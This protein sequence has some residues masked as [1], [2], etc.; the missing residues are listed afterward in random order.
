MSSVRTLSPPA[1]RLASLLPAMLLADDVEHPDGPLGL[2]LEVLAG[3]LTDLEDAVDRLARDPFVARASAEALPLIAALV[4]ARL[5]GDDTA[6]NRM[7]VA[8]T[9]GWRRRKGTLRTL[10][11]VLTRTSGWP[12]EVDEGFRSLLVTQDVTEPLPSRGWTALLWDPVGLADPLTRRAQH[13]DRHPRAAL[14]SPAAGD[15]LTEAL[16]RLGAPDALLLAASPRT[17]DLDGWA[18]PD[19]VAIR[20]SRVVVAE[21]DGVELRAPLPLAA[22]DGAALLG[23][24]LDPGGT[25]APVAARVVAEPLPVD[26]G[27]TVVHEPAPAPPDPRRPE[28]LTP[29]DLAADPAAVADGDALTLTVDDVLVVGGTTTAAPPGPLTWSPPGRDP[30]L[31][32]ADGGRPGPGDTWLLMAAALQDPATAATT[33]GVSEPSGEVDA[34]NAVVLEA[35]ASRSAAAVAV[36]PAGLVARAGATV[37]LRLERTAGELASWRRAG[38]GT[39]TSADVPPHAGEP[40]SGAVLA[41]PGGTGRVVRLTRDADVL[42]LARWEPGGAAWSS[43]PLDVE[44][45]AEEDR[46]G[47]VWL[48]AGPSAALVPDGQDV[49]LLAPSADGASTRAWLLSD[50]DAPT[51]QVAVADGSTERRP[52]TRAATAAC[53]AD[54]VLTLHGGQD[55]PEVLDDVWQLPLTGPGAGRWTQRRVRD[56]IARAGGALL[57]A[58]DGL[59]RLGG[60]DEPGRLSGD[61]HLLRPG[62]SRPRWEPLPSL[63]V[64]AG[65]GTLLASTGPDGMLRALVWADRTRPCAAELPSGAPAWRVGPLEGDGPHPP[66]EGDAVAAGDETLLVGPSPLPPSELVVSVGGRGVL[67]FLPAVDPRGAPTVLELDADGSTRVAYPP[68]TP[69][70][71]RLRLGLARETGPATGRTAPGTRLGARGRLDWAPLEVRQAALGP[72]TEPVALP[73][74]D[75]V[76]FDPRL[77]RVLLPAEVAGVRPVGD[78]PRFAAHVH[79]A[80]GAALGAGFAPSSGTVPARWLEP[81]DPVDPDRFALPAPATG[82][83]PTVTV[84]GPRTADAVL[85]LAQALQAAA[86]TPDAVVAVVGSPRL[87][88]ETLVLP[89]GSTTTVH[90]TDTQGYPVV[91]A[92]GS[93]TSLALVAGVPADPDDPPP[94]ALLQGLCLEGTVDLALTDGEVDLRWCDLGL[95]LGGVGVRVAGAGH[96]TPLL[97][98]TPPLAT[99]V[100]RLHGCHVAR[101]ELPPWVRVVAAGCTF[102]AGERTATAVDAAGAE[103]RLRECTV[104]GAVTAGVLEAT[105]CVLAGPVVCDRPDLGWLRRC[106]TEPVPGRPPRAWQSVEAAVSFADGRPAWPRYLVLDDNNASAVLTAGEGGRPP[107]AH[108]DRGRALRELTERSDDFLPLGMTAHHSDRAAADVHRMGRSRS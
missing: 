36:T 10:E 51:V 45:L 100:L 72:W 48:T 18:R 27:Y 76:A 107:G 89:V 86:G 96:H 35:T 70:P 20:T 78:R 13:D 44:A 52:G 37:G 71:V 59:V 67:A 69:A 63:G 4:G 54:G 90:A 53:V 58:A 22:V 11:D 73:L 62:A 94:H 93:G 21:R 77:G 29:T 30:V 60:A 91:A 85:D 64:P 42:S 3:P 33:L 106:V 38:D 15:D 57:A 68:G 103:L 17:V 19:A 74:D 50:L 80:R 40:V 102:D 41:D 24:R 25:D 47:A 108:A 101:L 23:L 26:T 9:V 31:R 7:V 2:L 43:S 82:R 97:R 5:L 1:Q 75:G 16:R 104:R 99:V 66:A 61:V 95:A 34:I 56:P 6:T 88:S 105:G 8:G 65:P 49:V 14:D 84:G 87:P 55:G 81:V 83:A 12:A 28:L 92:D 32:F 79:V 46:P 98:A 39:W